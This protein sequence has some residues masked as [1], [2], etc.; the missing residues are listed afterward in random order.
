[1]LKSSFLKMF[2]LIL[3]L[4]LNYT[5]LKSIR[6]TLAVVDLGNGANVIP[7]FEL[8]GALPASIFMTWGLS[9]LM[10]CMPLCKIFWS[11]LF[12]FL[13]F[14]LVFL[15]TIYPCLKQQGIG[16]YQGQFFLMLFYVMGELWKPAFAGILFWGL[17]NQ[18]L[19]LNEAK[20][21]YAPLMLGASL[22]AILAGPIV[23]VC[24]SDFVH[25]YFLLS[26]EKWKNS[27]HL[28]I[29]FVS[30]FGV[31]SGYL[32]R[33]IFLNFSN[34]FPCSRISLNEDLSLRKSFLQCIKIPQ[35]QLLSWIV[36]ADYIAYS[37]GEV[38]F[39][40]VL[41]IKFP[42]AC[43]YCTYLAAISSWC[44]FLTLI[45]ALFLTPFILQRFT[46]TV[47][48][49]VMPMCLFFTESAFFIVLRGKLISANWFNWSE[50]EWI[51]GII[52]LGSLQYC[53]CRATKYTFFDASKEIAFVLMPS[54]QMQGKLVIDGICARLGRGCASLLS[55]TLIT[56]FGGVLAS[57]CVTGIFAMTTS[58]S[59]IFA[60]FRLGKLLE[61]KSMREEFL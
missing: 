43:N 46:W 14:F 24:N 18:H 58:M 12:I 50:M 60:T 9:L 22:G 5:L 49:L 26:I 41:K 2:S 29:G 45:S 61:I 48:A 36:I 53:I 3:L 6:N 7:I 44:G 13:S 4:N 57:S 37:L 27:L 40:D 55:M 15:F 8:F 1:M 23:S 30:L 21:Y 31:L 19:T 11:V 10:R 39:L 20:K 16:F 52:F 17:V 28:M 54:F 59:W 38:I 25:Q 56:F 34:I 51:N 47:A 42:D 35:L 33:Q 32:Y